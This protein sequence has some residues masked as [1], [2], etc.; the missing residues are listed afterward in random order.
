M[1]CLVLLQSSPRLFTRS[2]WR[3]F[4]SLLADFMFSYQQGLQRFRVGC[5]FSG[6]HCQEHWEVYGVRVGL[7][8]SKEVPGLILRVLKSTH[9]GASSD[10]MDIAH[11]LVTVT[12]S[13]TAVIRLVLLPGSDMI[14][15]SVCGVLV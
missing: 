7:D 15:V 4:Q 6:I 13:F 1:F 2:R 11:T 12:N 8:G 3:W 10:F 5:S 9:P 14:K